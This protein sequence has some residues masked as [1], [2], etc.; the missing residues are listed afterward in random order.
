MWN[1]TTILNRAREYASKYSD[2][3][4]ELDNHYVQVA[5]EQ[6]AL[7]T[8][9]FPTEQS[10][11][12]VAN[13]REYTHSVVRVQRVLYDGVPL[14]ILDN[15]FATG[16]Y[17]IVYPS[18]VV[19]S[20]T[21]PAGKVIR[22]IGYGIP[23]NINTVALEPE[24]QLMDAVAMLAASKYLFLYSDPQTQSRANTLLGNYQ[25]VVQQFRERYVDT[26]R[27][28]D[29][30]WSE[31][32]LLARARE[33]ARQY[34]ER[35]NELD[36]HYVRDAFEQFCL[37]TLAFPSEQSITTTANQREYT[38]SVVRVKRVIYDGVPLPILDNGAT[39]GNYVV[40]HPNRIVLSFNPPAGRQIQVIGYG[41]PSNINSVVLEPVGQLMA[42]VAMLAASKYLMLSNE[43]NTQSRAT[44][45]LA[46]YQAIVQQFRERY[47]DTVRVENG[48]WSEL[49]LLARAREY[50]RR[51]TERVDGLDMHYVRGAFQQFC[52]D[53]NAF[54]A[55]HTI[56]TIGNQREYTHP[57]V[58]VNRV[59]LDGDE[60]IL[61]SEPNE[62]YRAC[63]VHP[64]RIV[65]SFDPQP[66]QQ[67]RIVG[68]SVPAIDT[69]YLEPAER[70][71][72]G[73]AMLSAYNY[74]IRFAEPQQ[75]QSISLYQMEYRKMVDEFSARHLDGIRKRGGNLPVVGHISL[76]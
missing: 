33:Y 49:S 25:A 4:Q 45:L 21:P 12:T 62:Y 74:L 65:L 23:S 10:I 3:Y 28:E 50:A 47:V 68:Y 58:R 29:N 55:E 11:T 64:N 75:I 27:V 60:L 71:M 73:I 40:V 41:I 1:S 6:F 5:F 30:G 20:F 66:N 46:N 7:D 15:S 18:R 35:V 19:L 36:N 52:L 56:N 54:P 72:S 8:L 22:V 76:T 59:L 14:P 37:D 16:N 42:C 69:V 70:L 34:T 48:G 38:H 61:L 43:P 44:A 17:A 13:Q 67:L 53:T 51:Y 24:Q 63:G 9:A 32:G 2:A 39:A 26:V 57:L 31:L